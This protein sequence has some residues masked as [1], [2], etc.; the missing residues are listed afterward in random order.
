MNIA[1]KVIAMFSIASVCNAAEISASKLNDIYLINNSSDRMKEPQKYFSHEY[2][3]I[4]M[5]MSGSDSSVRPSQLTGMT[6]SGGGIRSSNY[7]LGLL[8]GLYRHNNSINKLGYI[9]SVSGG[10]WANGAYWAWSLSDKVLFECLDKAAEL[11]KANVDCESAKMLSTDQVVFGK[12]ENIQLKTTKNDW[13]KRIENTYIPHCDIDSGD[14]KTLECY[15]YN[16]SRKPY[17]IVNST[18]SAPPFTKGTER[19][20]PFHFTLDNFGTLTD[21]YIGSRDCNSAGNAGFFAKSVSKEYVWVNKKLYPFNADKP[22]NTLSA[23]LA[24]SSAVVS[25]ATMLSYKYEIIVNT[26]NSKVGNVRGDHIA[27]IRNDYWLSDGGHS[28]NLGLLPLIERGV[29]LIVVSYMGKDNNLEKDPWEDL[30][31]AAQQAKN[32]LG[33]TVELPPPASKVDSEDV[34]IHESNYKCGNSKGGKLLHVK[35]S[36]ANSEKFISHLKEI[37]NTELV[38]YLEK[39]DIENNRN[40]LKDRFPQTKTFDQV[41]DEELVRA[42]YLFGRWIAEN[43]LGKALDVLLPAP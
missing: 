26:K 7:H 21:C 1:T 18:H 28:D 11:G 23:A 4:N 42:Y 38:D 5:R 34:F 12:G 41:Y 30:K 40:H 17:I 2:K 25:G 8:S 6:L 14:K 9:S 35:P 33:C 10:S 31:L 19:N 36:Y 32:I 15:K 37:K 3:Q 16:Y 27:E 24:S 20:I 39:T 29:D 22:R 43:H 13:I